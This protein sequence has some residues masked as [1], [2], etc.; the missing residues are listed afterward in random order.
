[1]FLAAGAL[2]GAT[3]VGSLL[4]FAG[5]TVAT[6]VG[7]TVAASFGASLF[8]APWVE[9]RANLITAGTLLLLGGLIAAGLL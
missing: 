1:V 4:V 6:I 9:R 7:L 5:V 3:A 2:G 8:T